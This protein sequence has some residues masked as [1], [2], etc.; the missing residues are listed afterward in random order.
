MT[1]ARWL[2]LVS[3]VAGLA[4]SGQDKTATFE[5]RGSIE[6]DGQ[7]EGGWWY[8]QSESGETYTPIEGLPGE[9]KVP[10]MRVQAT[11]VATEAVSFLPGPFVRVVRLEQLAG[12]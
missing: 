6:F 5:T 9:F 2:L 3:M 8:I 11:L 4:C 7:L 10:G 1:C 12:F